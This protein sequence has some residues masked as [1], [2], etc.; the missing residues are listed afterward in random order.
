[1]DASFNL[2]TRHHGY[3]SNM[4][5]TR[6]R[7]SVM[8]EKHL[9]IT[10]PHTHTHTGT[11]DMK[12]KLKAK[13]KG[14]RPFQPSD[15]KENGHVSNVG[16]VRIRSKVRQLQSTSSSSRL[17]GSSFSSSSV[18]TSDSFSTSASTFTSTSTSRDKYGSTYSRKERE[19][20]LRSRRSPLHLEH[21]FNHH[22]QQ[23]QQYDECHDHN[24]AKHDSRQYQDDIVT[25]MEQDNDEL[26]QIYKSA[27][28]SAFPSTSVSSLTLGPDPVEH[29]NPQEQQS[30][31]NDNFSGRSNTKCLEEPKGEGKEVE[32]ESEEPFKHND[33]QNDDF[34]NV[35]LS[36][37]ADVESES[38]FFL[39]PRP[40]RMTRGTESCFSDVTLSD[41]F[42]TPM[43][44]PF[45][46]AHGASSL[47]SSSSLRV[48]YS[49][50]S[51]IQS[52][53]GSAFYTISR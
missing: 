8:D 53:I 22:Q 26:C 18:N 37:R 14:G 33:D 21:S 2:R 40:L 39:S 47:S 24:D 16:N 25:D 36:F 46:F 1:M 13:V 34:F 10:S 41:A 31:S 32:L 15:D 45:S 28:A 9:N 43:A 27:L 6:M 19:P 30:L 5:G 48:S 23:Q 52:S 38:G 49:P 20:S 7:E 44:T 42:V 12:G 4:G 3:L 17:K 50:K 29:Y 11:H 35:P 51:S